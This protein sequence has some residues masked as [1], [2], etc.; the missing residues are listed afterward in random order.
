MSALVDAQQKFSYMVGRLL[1]FIETTEYRCTMGEA[2]RTPEQ[3]AIYAKTGAGIKN[4]LHC[5]RL[6]L[7][8]NFRLNGELVETPEIIALFWESIGGC[9]GIRFGDSP[10]FSKAYGGRK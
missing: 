5:D 1:T 2:W 10:H 7:D 9:A 8:L 6:A 3:A 4:S